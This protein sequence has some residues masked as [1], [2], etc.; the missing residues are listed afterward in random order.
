[1]RR[2]VVK[3]I[4][5]FILFSFF[6]IGCYT[7][8]EHPRIET[9]NALGELEKRKI[10]IYEDCYSCHTYDEI[11]GTNFA[12]YPKFYENR[13]SSNYGFSVEDSASLSAQEEKL[14]DYRYSHRF[15]GY[16]QTPW[17]ISIPRPM[18]I[19]G[20]EENASSENQKRENLRTSQ[21]ERNESTNSN[22]QSGSARSIGGSGSS[23]S[24]NSEKEHKSETRTRKSSDEESKSSK[25]RTGEREK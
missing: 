1:M 8:I 23:S 10:G 16:D 22:L 2:F 25:N 3:Y 21:G 14:A 7:L 15:Y 12:A 24:A 13:N 6:G 4:F 11:K 20:V 9:L 19:I 17:W 5:F 18:K